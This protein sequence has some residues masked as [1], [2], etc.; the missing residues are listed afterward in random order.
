M[1]KLLVLWMVLCLG[2]VLF[3][4]NT[5]GIPNITNYFRQDYNAGQQNW[6]IAQDSRGIMYFA[7]NYGLLT[8]DGTF[9]R[10]YRIPNATIVRSLAIDKN[11]RIYVGGQQEFGYFSPGQEG[12]LVYTSLSKQLKADND[13]ADVWT[14][15]IVQ[16]RIFFHAYRKIFEYG[17]GTVKTYNSMHWRFLGYANNQL[18]AYEYDLGLVYYNNGQWLPRIRTGTLPADIQIRSVTNLGNDSLLLTSISHGLFILKGDVIKP[19]V[20][21]DI[22]AIA[23]H[24][25]FGACLLSP[26]KIALNTNLGGCIIID[27]K[28]NF[29]QRL[30][31]NEGIQNNNV[32]SL[33][34]DKDQNLWLGLDNGIDL[35]T[36]NNAIKNIFPEPGDHSTGYTSI[37]HNNRLYLGLT[38]GLFKADLPLAGTDL[39]YAKSAFSLVEN[40]KGQVWNLSKVNG[41]LFMGHTLGAFVVNDNKAT[42]FDSKSGFWIFLPL[43]DSV[44]NSVILA[45]TYNGIN[46][47]NYT[48]KRIINHNVA[49]RFESAR[50][51]VKHKN[52][53][54]AIHPYK[55]LYMVSFNAMNQPVVANYID[56]KKIL[57]QNHNHLYRIAGRMVLTTDNGIFEFDDAI[58][59][60]KPSAYFRKLFGDI[61]IDYLKD[62][63]AGNIWFC[64]RK[65][66][67]VAEKINGSYRLVYIPELDDRIM[68]NGFEH[69]NII[70]SSNVLIAAE[71]GFFHLNYAQYKK[72]RHFFTTLIR[73]VQVA[74][75]K[76]DLIYGG[77]TGTTASLSTPSIPYASNSLHFECSAMIYGQQQ[78]I[79]YSYFLEGFDSGWSDWNRK[80]EKEYTN[81]PPGKYVFHV[82][83]RNNIEN[84][85]PVA[86]FSFTILPPWY[87]SWWA[88]L[89]YGAVSFA[90]LYWFYKRQQWK[91][92]KREALKLMQQQQRYAE[93]QK[94]L[95]MQHEL[96]MGKR[97]KEI[98]Q[99]KNEKLQ[100]DIEYK[101]SQLASTAMNLVRKME[102]FSKIKDDL[103]GFKNNEEF[104]AGSKELQKII[105]LIDSELDLTREWEQFTEHFDQVHSNF[106]KKLKEQWPDLTPTELKLA[107]YLRLNLTTKEIAHLMSISI[108]GVETGRYRL[109]KKLGLTSNDTSLYDYLMSIAG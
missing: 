88:Y 51:V 69:I 50:Y 86:S 35:V 36:Y 3:A 11:D 33:F 71:K 24:N 60:F 101:N 28:G 41:T 100:A 87:R 7:N 31:K 84:E 17:N 95:Q 72:T 45:G 13:F 109:R 67:G 70:D 4:Q 26:D 38:T 52:I 21:P 9:W 76:E 63:Q 99:L 2:H 92:R 53:I 65:R 1:R 79:T 98:I 37:I 68:S 14:I 6:H 83:S 97:E 62:D 85:S 73:L 15:Q 82:K 57:S 81:L 80:T 55:G 48:N 64:S 39:S 8:F 22:K 54:W 25:I 44:S 104:R 46:F 16:D 94:Q 40:S 56:K 19:F 89:L 23:A 90:L 18:L 77:Y 32:H 58:N 10:T 75:K 27:R 29:I 91:Y 49:V 59:D 30:S 43:Y 47:Y 107:A 108:R 42:V 5:I 61:P 66:V 78:N 12:E 106:L 93:E 105:R 20:T 96:Q 102:I 103:S 34:I 74:A